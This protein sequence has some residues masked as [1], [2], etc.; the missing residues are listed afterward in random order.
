[1][2]EVYLD[3]IKLDFED[4]SR[5]STVGE[6]VDAI[7]SDLTGLRRFVMELWIDGQELREW[8]G[9]TVLKKP[10][11]GFS[12]FNLRTASMEEVALEGLS[13]AQEY[14]KVTK[15]SICACSQDI[16]IGKPGTDAGYASIFESLVEIVK[17]IDALARGG[18]RYGMDLF[19]ENPSAYYSPILKCL[20]AMRDARESGDSVTL[21]D[22]LEY[23]LL[24]FLEEMDENL[25]HLSA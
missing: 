24:P 25:F 13:L 5:S 21:A 3:G 11:S 14:I 19:K 20:E 8:R 23:E 18:E 22:L 16:R 10:I 7:E 9:D 17:T 6:L 4:R 1:M 2:P 15:D 12:D